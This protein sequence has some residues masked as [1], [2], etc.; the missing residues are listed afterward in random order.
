M[1]KTWISVVLALLLVGVLAFTVYSQQTDSE[2]APAVQVLRG[3]V[4]QSVPVELTLLMSTS[5]G[6]QTVT[7]PLQLSVNLNVGPMEA[8][9]LN[10]ALEPASQFVS[11][12]AGVE[13][14]VESAAITGTE[15]I[16]ETETVTE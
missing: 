13:A 2:D 5:T 15:S 6:V 8:I 14:I 12:I 11:P 1:R 7:V 9:D 10:M 16:S 3:G 4:S